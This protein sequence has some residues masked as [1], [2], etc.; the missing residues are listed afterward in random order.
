MDRPTVVQSSVLPVVNRETCQNE[1]FYNKE[2]Y[3]DV[4]KGMFCAGTIDS[5]ICMGDSGGPAVDF[6]GELVGIAS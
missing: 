5:H 4:T 6:N 3:S 1:Y 2:L